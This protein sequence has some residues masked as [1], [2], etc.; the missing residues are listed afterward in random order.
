MR[1]SYSLLIC[2]F[3]V[4]CPSKAQVV[5]VIVDQEHATLSV[6]NALV[7]RVSAMVK[8]NNANR[9]LN[10]YNDMSS[11]HAAI[12]IIQDRIENSLFNV[13]SALKNALAVK[14]IPEQIAAIYTEL[15]VV[16]ET[17]K[18]H[19]EFSFLGKKY[20]EYG[21]EQAIALNNEVQVFALSGSSNI[22][23]NYRERDEVIRDIRVRLGLI[24]ANLQLV[25]ITLN[26]AVK[27]GFLRAATPFGNWLNNDKILVN[28]IIRRSK[29]L[30]Q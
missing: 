10:S 26:R 5:D 12:L 14:D 8:S 21:A 2:F 25:T 30:T 15:N 1:K 24:R 6:D 7:R 23:M 19:P 13:N 9:T 28:D 27:I 4:F 18:N 22:M 17:C 3:L 16:M 20:L 29:Y 11:N